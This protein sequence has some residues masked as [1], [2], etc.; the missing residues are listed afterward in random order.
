MDKKY[1]VVVDMNPEVKGENK[2][3]S[4]E[5]KCLTEDG[6]WT[7][8]ATGIARS[9][10]DAFHDA[11]NKHLFFVCRD[12]SREQTLNKAHRFHYDEEDCKI[13]EMWCSNFAQ[14]EIAHH[15]GLDIRYVRQL[16]KAINSL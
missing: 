10:E 4:W 14:E 15:M 7:T 13:W 3:Y 8:M 16:I 2:F 6:E 9:A 1:Q 5:V 11:E 12:Y